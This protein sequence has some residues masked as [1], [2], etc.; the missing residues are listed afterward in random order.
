MLIRRHPRRPRP[1]YRIPRRRPDGVLLLSL[2]VIAFALLGLVG[3]LLL[4]V[5]WYWLLAAS[6]SSML[7]L[8][9]GV[10]LY[11]GWNWARV[12]Y[13]W[14]VPSST[15][16]QTVGAGSLPDAAPQ[17]I[18]FFAIYLPIAFYLTRPR[19]LAYF[20]TDESGRSRVARP[21]LPPK[22]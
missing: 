18:G 17:L 14:L 11:R 5:A 19:V 3:V 7:Q 1:K 6:V 9:M 16:V 4:R 10:G 12:W 13:L 8:V 22:N 2:F 20:H 15:A 21:V